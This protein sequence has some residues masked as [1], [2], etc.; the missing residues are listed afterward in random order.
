MKNHRVT[1]K[2]GFTLIELLVV[3]AIIAILA[4]ILFPVFARARENARRS[5]CSSNLK[6]IGLGLMQYTQDYDE[7]YIRF[8]ENNSGGVPNWTQAVQPYVKSTQMFVCPSNPNSGANKAAAGTYQ[9]IAYPEIR[10]SYGMNRNAP[11]SEGSV[12]S[13]A[14]KIYVSES[15]AEW[16]LEV[17]GELDRHW[18]GHLATANY[19]YFD[20]HVK[21]LGPVRTGTPLNQWGKAAGACPGFESAET[22]INCDTPDSALTAQ[23]AA[24]AD[25][26]K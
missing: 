24:V 2:K 15:V 10:R 1:L 18:A 25:K 4:A 19:L 6:Q 26:Y 16:D 9:G 20:G 17:V 7:K 5:S 3:I 8:G 22:E 11:L 21:S 13:P 14:T 12:A 23:L